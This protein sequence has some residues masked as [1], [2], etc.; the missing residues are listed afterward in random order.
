MRTALFCPD[1]P[2]SNRQG[3]IQ[4][5]SHNL[6]RGLSK[7][8]LDVAV[9][10]GEGYAGNG[11]DGTVP[12]VE[13]PGP[14]DR[15]WALR[16][17]TELESRSVSL[18]NL[19]YSPAMFDDPN[20]FAWSLL[21][22]RFPAVVSFHTLWGGRNIVAALRLLHTARAVIATNSEILHLLRRYCPW[23]MGK[24]VFIP[25]G[26]NIAPHNQIAI[27]EEVRKRYEITGDD[28]VLVYFGMAYP[29]KGLELLLATASCLERVHGLAF[30]LLC[31]GGGVSDVLD[32]RAEKRHRATELGLEHRI[33]WTG[34]IPPTHVSSLLT[35]SDIV[36][37]LYETGVSDRRGTMMAA[38]AHGR[39]IVTTPPRIS[40]PHFVNGKNMTWP[41]SMSPESLSRTIVRLYENP[42]LS[43]SLGRGALELASKL[44]WS[45]IAKDTILVF[46]KAEDAATT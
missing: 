28:C 7:R 6:A 41:Q 14:W 22:S 9:I 31:V 25:I 46:E 35:M 44:E 16:A 12:V 19:Q 24:T 8:G 1:Y 2:P 36:L 13:L 27:H 45:E 18:I 37:L 4:D 15:S 40:M 21:A 10:T 33:I 32:Y 20:R 29:G 5:Y 3:G 11:T 34:R 17:I 39:P 38:L 43:E 42:A 30:K 23:Y 26:S